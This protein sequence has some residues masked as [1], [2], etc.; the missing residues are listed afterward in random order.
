M[1]VIHTQ[2]SS[3]GPVRLSAADGTAAVLLCEHLTMMRRRH[4]KCLELMLE[5]IVAHPPFGSGVVLFIS[6]DN[7]QFVAFVPL[8]ILLGNLLFI[9]S[10]PLSRIDRTAVLAA[11]IQPPAVPACARRVIERMKLC[12]RLHF[13]TEDASFLRF[14][15]APVFRTAGDTDKTR[16]RV[17]DRFVAPSSTD[18]ILLEVAS[19]FDFP[20][21]AARLRYNGRYVMEVKLRL[22]R[23]A[24]LRLL[25]SV[26]P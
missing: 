4:A 5:P 13:F 25:A 9:V 7:L 21:Q 23:R 10:A 8:A 3:P 20:A 12:N 17:S 22:G 18:C 6:L 26:R 14:W 1:A 11:G 16:E 2:F 24:S 19:G 15:D